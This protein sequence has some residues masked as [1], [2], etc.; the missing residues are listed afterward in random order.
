M[1]ASYS[2]AGPSYLS[3]RVI[4]GFDTSSRFTFQDM[5]AFGCYAGSRRQLFVQID[6]SH[7][8]NGNIFPGNPGVKVPLTITVGRAF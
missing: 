4:D 8:S 7:F 6:V 1:F 5:L 2:L 3:R